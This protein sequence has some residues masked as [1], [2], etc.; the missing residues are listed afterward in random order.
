M[1]P[2]KNTEKNTDKPKT[3]EVEN[4]NVEVKNV[5]PTTNATASAVV[6]EDEKKPS[7]TII[8]SPADNSSINESVFKNLKGLTQANKNKS[9]GYFLE[10]DNLENAKNAF[11]TLKLNNKLLEKYGFYNLFVKVSGLTDSSDYQECK[12]KITGYVKEK[13]N[14]NVP[15][16]KLYRKQD[17]YIGCAKLTVDT[18]KAMDKILDEASDIKNCTVGNLNLTFYPFRNDKKKPDNGNK[19]YSSQ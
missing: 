2:K 17:K 3:I 9:N 5:A 11:D 16:F 19:I 10:F 8:L 13:I 4:V 15:F 6:P 1:P 14:G 7:L 18:K 12:D